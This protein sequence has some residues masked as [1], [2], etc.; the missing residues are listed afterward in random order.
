AIQKMIENPLAELILQGKY[1]D[2]ETVHIDS[3]D[4]ELVFS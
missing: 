2:G 4:G 1:S 3:K